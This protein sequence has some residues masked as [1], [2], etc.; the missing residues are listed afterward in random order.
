M[1]FRK[2]GLLENGKP[3]GLRAVKGVLMWTVSM[4]V[5]GWGGESQVLGN[6][7][8]KSGIQMFSQLGD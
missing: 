4:G 5:G 1:E 7:V 3:F 2:V 6:P 8:S